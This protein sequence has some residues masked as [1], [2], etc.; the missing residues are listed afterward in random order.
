MKYYFGSDHAGFEMKKELIE[1]LKQKGLEVEDLG[2]N[3]KESCDY[4]DYAKKVGEKVAK[5]NEKGILICG[6][7]I[8]MS[9]TA[10]KIKG[11]RA[12]LIHNEFTGKYAKKH[13]N[14][15]I[16]CLGSRVV[17]FQT[18]KKAVD[19]WLIE[20]FEGGRHERRTRKIDSI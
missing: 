15:N 18:A 6:T 10:N 16:I 2:T 3:S 4:P 17:D 13:N 11:I 7:G 1:H 20:E 14:A 5:Q 8:G 9:M 19:A 12:A